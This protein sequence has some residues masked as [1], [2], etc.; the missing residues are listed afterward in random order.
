METKDC[1]LKMLPK[2]FEEVLL[3]Y[4]CL[5]IYKRKGL[6]DRERQIDMWRHMRDKRM[7]LSGQKEWHSEIKGLT[8]NINWKILDPKG[9]SFHRRHIL[10]GNSKDAYS[11]SC[12]CNIN[13]ASGLISQHICW[14]KRSNR[15][16][17]IHNS[18]STGFNSRKI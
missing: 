13:F 15:F 4:P 1:S 16:N 6:W 17:R 5:G 12:R 18:T 3:R 14:G 8:N 7:K 10:Q 9:H 2:T 11:V